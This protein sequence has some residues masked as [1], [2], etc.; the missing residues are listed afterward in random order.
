MEKENNVSNQSWR[1]V[2]AVVQGE[3][4]LPPSR[5]LAIHRTVPSTKNYP[6]PNINSSKIQKSAPGQLEYTDLKEEYASFKA[7]IIKATRL[8]YGN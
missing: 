1:F 8:S 3:G 6:P 4:L 7:Y 2:R 5:H